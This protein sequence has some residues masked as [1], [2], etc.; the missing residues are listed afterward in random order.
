M[1]GTMDTLTAEEFTR[2][3]SFAGWDFENVWS[4]ENGDR[5]VLR[6]VR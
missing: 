5:P 3:E 1:Q 4:L 6:D 2:V